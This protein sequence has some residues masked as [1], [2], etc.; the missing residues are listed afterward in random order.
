MMNF[1]N[2]DSGWSALKA[3]NRAVK[4]LVAALIALLFLEGM[5]LFTKETVV[6]L[7]PWT[8]TSDAVIEKNSASR[9]YKEAWGLALSEL[10][11]NITPT[12]VDFVIE[13][14]KPLLAPSIYNEVIRNAAEQAIFLKEDRITQN[15]IPRSVEYEQSTDKVFVRGFSFI[16][17]VSAGASA[18]NGLDKPVRKDLTFEF[19]ISVGNYMPVIRDINIYDGRAR[20]DKVLK[21]IEKQEERKKMREAKRLKA[22]E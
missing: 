22:D 21:R 11:G 7:K 1:K 5:F 6:I 16:S 14:L 19:Q 8:L 17:G 3:E 12:N 18:V 10:I 13:R 20:T 9:A 15:F 4:A 2:F